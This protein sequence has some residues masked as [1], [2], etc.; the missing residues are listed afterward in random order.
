MSHPWCKSWST[1]AGG[2]VLTLHVSW[3]PSLRS[4]ITTNRENNILRQK[5]ALCLE[6]V[7]SVITIKSMNS[8]GGVDSLI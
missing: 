5:N 7:L 3:A 4:D 6:K 8:L 2:C 1:E